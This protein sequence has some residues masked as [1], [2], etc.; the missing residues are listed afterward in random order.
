M[1]NSHKNQREIKWAPS[2]ISKWNTKLKSQCVLWKWNCKVKYH[3]EISK[4][5][6][7]EILIKSILW[8]KNGIGYGLCG[9]IEKNF[10][11]EMLLKTFNIYFI[12]YNITGLSCSLQSNNWQCIGGTVT[13]FWYYTI[14]DSN[15][16]KIQYSC[17]ECSVAGCFAKI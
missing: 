16:I 4:C 9:A 2:E 1:W 14:I 6:Q 12:L 17:V 7:S 10:I 11:I 5:N 13:K 3:S 15:G 8:R